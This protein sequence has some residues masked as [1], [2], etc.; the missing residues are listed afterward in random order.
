MFEPMM[1]M[2]DDAVIKVVGVGGGGGNAVEHMVR[3]SIEGVEFISVNTDA[4]ALRKTSVSSVIQIGGDIT[5]GLGAGANPQVGRDAALEDR[6]RIKEVLTGADMVFIAAGMGGGTGTGAAPVIAEVAKELGVLTV[7]VVTKPFSF[8]GKKRLAFAEQG[9]EELS[10][11]V[12]SLITIPNE[13]L[14]KV[15]GRGVTLLE[16]FAS[17]NDVLKNAVQGI[18]ELITRPGMINVDFADVRT[19]MSEMGHAMMGSGIAK[20]ED[21][22]EEA[23]ETAISSPLLEDIDLAGARGVL[24]NITA[25]LDMRLDEFETVGNTVNAFASDNATVVIG[26]SLDPDMTDEIRVTVVATG[27]GTEKKPDI[28]LVAGGK[29]KVAPTPQPQVAAQTAPKVEEKMAQP[30]QEKTEV[31]P[32]VKPQPT[33]S[34]VSS[35]TGASQ[36]AAPKAEKESGYLDIPAFLRRQAD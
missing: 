32:Q 6:E 14:L 35:G 19:V 2:S 15:L 16:A 13:K 8:E 7:A 3:E 20:G 4:Q 18:A 24:V 33:T 23:A 27:I 17:A 25:G 31:K 34:P 21:R 10:K 29:A 5:K 1:E 30:L 11:H 26:T 9:I 36:S 12:D 28:T 22:A